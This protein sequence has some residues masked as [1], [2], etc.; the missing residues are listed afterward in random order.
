MYRHDPI[1][2]EASSSP[3]LKRPHHTE[4]VGVVSEAREASPA[5]GRADVLWFTVPGTAADG[6]RTACSLG[7]SGS[8]CGSPIIV[9]VVT[10]LDVLS[11]VAVHFVKTVSISPTFSRL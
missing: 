9:I 3:T 7:H 8:V 4:A 1:K 10:V 5:A 11:R 2:P 6:A